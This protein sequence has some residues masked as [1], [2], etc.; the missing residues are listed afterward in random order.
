M[1][2]KKSDVQLAV[3]FSGNIFQKADLSR[4]ELL[5]AYAVSDK[6]AVQLNLGYNTSTRTYEDNK[7]LSRRD[8]SAIRNMEIGIGY[9]HPLAN[10]FHFECYGLLSFNK[11][12]Y[13]S[14][15]TQ[16]LI[17]V[18]LF[19]ANYRSIALQPAIAYKSDLVSIIFSN[20]FSNVKY[21]NISGEFTY[22]GE[23]QSN[24]LAENDAHFLIEPALTFRSGKGKVQ[25][26]AQWLRSYNLTKENFRQHE[27][28]FTAGVV[29]NIGYKPED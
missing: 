7:E 14:T 1:L 5:S 4:Y 3:N 2:E 26:Q 18:E 29:W 19:N 13:Q 24:Y 11:L 8:E 10:K 20:R 12:K 9:N 17:G 22:N 28:V 27:Q 15:I 6:V 23:S 21:S 25:L 16:P